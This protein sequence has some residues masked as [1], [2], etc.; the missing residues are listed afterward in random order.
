MA[1]MDTDWNLKKVAP[2]LK[3]YNCYKSSQRGEQAI[4][5]A[6]AAGR[7]EKRRACNTSLEFDIPPPITLSSGYGSP[8]TKLSDFRQSVWSG[9]ERECK[10][11]LKKKNVPRIITSLLM[12]S[13]PIRISHR[14][15]RYRYSNSR[16][17][18]ACC[19][20][21]SRP[22]ARPPRRACSKAIKKSQKV[23]MVLW[24]LLQN[25]TGA[26]CVWVRTLINDLITELT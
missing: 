5:G 14:L 6:L 2:F 26:I 16:N 23:K 25:S 18:V 9:K 7:G 17:V 1:R 11:T 15:F 22:V 13:P 10:Q 12:S 4:R 19:P 24:Y 8:S 3:C 21:F 20:S